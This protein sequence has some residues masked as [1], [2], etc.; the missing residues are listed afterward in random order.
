[1]ECQDSEARMIVEYNC[2]DGEYT[3][4]SRELKLPKEWQKSYLKFR[5]CFYD[6]DNANRMCEPMGS[7][8]FVLIR[9]KR[10]LILMRKYLKY[11]R[12]NVSDPKSAIVKITNKYRVSFVFL[13][14]NLYFK[15]IFFY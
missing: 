12:K 8:S 13:L 14:L 1:M 4:W 9:P 7:I 15:I 5:S 2:D 11:T 6:R 3:K 10:C